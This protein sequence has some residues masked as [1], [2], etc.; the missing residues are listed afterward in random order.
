M[1]ERP[2]QVPASWIFHR[3]EWC[4]PSRVPGLG[5][6]QS[7]IVEQKGP[8]VGEPSSK[9]ERRKGMVRG[10]PRILVSLCGCGP[11]LLDSDN[12]IGGCKP[13]RDAIARWIGLDDNDSNI[14]WEYAQ[15]QTSGRNGTIVRIERIK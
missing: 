4:H 8:L 13:L 1:N 6:L 10:A 3:G 12:F 7:H 2:P 9:K 15:C 14:R 5:K 11:R